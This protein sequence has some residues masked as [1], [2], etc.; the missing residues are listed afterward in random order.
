MAPRKNQVPDARVFVLDAL[1][2]IIVPLYRK[3]VC[4]GVGEDLPDSKELP[5]S[6]FVKTYRCKDT[7]LICNFGVSGLGFPITYARRM[8]LRFRADEQ[9][10]DINQAVSTIMLRSVDNGYP[11]TL[12]RQVRG[13]L[14]FREYFSRTDLEK[15]SDLEIVELRTYIDPRKSRWM[16]G[17]GIQ[18]TRK[19]GYD[20]LGKRVS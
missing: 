9:V 1:S 16:A 14:E 4:F 5:K 13:N 15:P 17:Q 2:G 10:E 6:A 8:V 18:G 7:N 20:V 19:V 12:M 3:L 11:L